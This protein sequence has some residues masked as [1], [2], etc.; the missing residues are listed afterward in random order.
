MSSTHYAFIGGSAIPYWDL[1]ETVTWYFSGASDWRFLDAINRAFSAW[2]GFISVDFQMVSSA[3]A[4]DIDLAITY[5]DGSGHLDAH[6]NFV[7][8]AGRTYKIGYHENVQIEFDSYDYSS[9]VTEFYELVLHEVG[10]ALGLAHPEGTPQGMTSGNAYVY[11]DENT[12]MWG[13]VGGSATDLTA[14]DIAGARVL[15]GAESVAGGTDAGNTFATALAITLPWST[16]SASVGYSGDTDDY[17]KFV[18]SGNGTVTVQLSGLTADLDLRGYDP[19]TI[20]IAQSTASGTANES[21]TFSVQA[22]QT[23]Y[24]HVDPY[25]TAASSYSLSASFAAQQQLADL[26]VSGPFVSPATIQPS[27]SVAISYFVNNI[28]AGA[29]SEFDVG[30]YL[31]ADQTI[32]T[33]D[34]FLSYEHIALLAGNA[35]V[36]GVQ[37]FTLS[38]T[39]LV[40]GATYYIGVIADDLD[41]ITNELSETNNTTYAA[42]TVTAPQQL[43]DLTA[44][45]LVMAS[46]SVVTGGTTTAHFTVTN[47]GTYAAQGDVAQ[48]YLSTDANITTSDIGLSPISIPFLSAGESFTT[49]NYTLNFGGIAPG[50]YYLGAIA[51]WN[52]TISESNEGNNVSNVV[53]VTVAPQH[54]FNGDG[55]SDLIWRNASTGLNYEWEMNGRTISSSGPLGGD[56]TWS[57][58]G[59]GDFNGDGHTDLLWRNA[60][61]GLIYEWDMNGRT[62]ISAGALGGD[63]TWS[64]TG[65]GDF[66]G[67]GRTDLL[68]RNAST[69]QIYEWEMN[70]R[71]IVSAG[72]LGGDSTWSITGTGDF[73]GDGHT[74]LLWRNASTGLIYEWEMNGRAIVSA[75]AL[76][77]DSTWSVTGTGDFNGDGRTDL[78]WRNASTGLIYEWEMN[79]R[80]IL[81]A[82]ALGGDSTWSPVGTGDFNGDGRSDILWQNAS[83]GL[84]YEWEMTGR[85]I[86]SAGALGGD[87]TW[88]IAA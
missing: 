6:G 38:S 46:T 27:Q 75:G 76:G 88:L 42:V 67:D 17:L 49:G 86:V 4:A 58:T 21:I 85:T 26:T 78:L 18:A 10:H 82:G 72:A 12:V 7:N 15:Y 73:N 16:T 71:S 51:D 87:H 64:V 59:T 65:T 81:S 30:V 2:D 39:S 19:N 9:Y 20:E 25:N 8:T 63:T 50:T 40:A 80:T 34:T 35:T 55:H 31:S 32:T 69:G 53:T 22:G 48:I 47:S 52:N 33:S 77:G 83:S 3:A 79:G 56:S 74:D 24:F 41:V 37:Y 11:G 36:A 70:G 66:N 14:W 61:T 43:P 5:I 62:V 1:N 68:W 84:I 29:A 57:I 28:G 44:S 60:S 54:D 45:A 13:N 23:Y